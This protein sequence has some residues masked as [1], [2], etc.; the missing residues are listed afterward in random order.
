MDKL[1][2]AKTTHPPKP[3]NTPLSETALHRLLGHRIRSPLIH[4]LAQADSLLSADTPLPTKVIADVGFISGEA[5]RA[6][7]LYD[8]ALALFELTLSPNHV[9]KIDSAALISTFCYGI[10]KNIPAEVMGYRLI[11][12]VPEALPSIAVNVPLLQSALYLMIRL[13]GHDL[14]SSYVQLD[15]QVTDSELAI[16]TRTM[17]TDTTVI[18]ADLEYTILE[19][20]ARACGGRFDHRLADQFLS[21]SLYLPIVT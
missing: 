12:A 7:E 21:L 4:I 6:L 10:E 3:I 11:W 14:H 9:S 2:K 15:T 8:W 1:K 19:S 16:Q 18:Q 17:I 13:L 5:H 20:V